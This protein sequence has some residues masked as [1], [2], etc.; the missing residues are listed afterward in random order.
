MVLTKWFS[1]QTI[2]H[3]NCTVCDSNM[4]N[5]VWM[6]NIPRASHAYGLLCDS[7]YVQAD[8]I[9]W[10][11]FSCMYYTVVTSAYSNTQLH[12]YNASITLAQCISYTRTMH[13]FHSHNA[14]VTHAQWISYTRTIHQLHSHNASVTLAQCISYTRTIHQLHRTMHQLHS[15]NA[16]VTLVQCISY[17]QC[18]KYIWS[19][20]SDFKLI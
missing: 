1:E 17:T 11:T 14:S 9:S 7:P 8:F 18:I 15:H 16:S 3:T 6:S 10:Q 13:Q 19:I 20:T 4:V 2:S 12:S 5:D